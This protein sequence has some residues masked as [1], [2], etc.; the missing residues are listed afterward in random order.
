ML[1]IIK[2]FKIELL[3]VAIFIFLFA[4]SAIY[5]INSSGMSVQKLIKYLAMGIKF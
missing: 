5:V 3:K 2:S 1:Q 4:G